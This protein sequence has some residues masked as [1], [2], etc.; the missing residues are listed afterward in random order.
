MCTQQLMGVAK[1]LLKNQ[2]KH[3]IMTRLP[4][5]GWVQPPELADN[6]CMH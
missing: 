5:R 4:T 3:T 6:F 2:E 1:K